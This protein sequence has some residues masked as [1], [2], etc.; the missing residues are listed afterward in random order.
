MLDAAERRDPNAVEHPVARPSCFYEPLTSGLCL[1]I[2]A[3]AF[4][5]T[6]HKSD[7]RSDA[8]IATT[9]IGHGRFPASAIRGRGCSSSAWRLR[10]TVRIGPAGCLRAMAPVA[11]AIS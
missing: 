3:R 4:A 8:R 6:A 1:A 9:R 2:A 5:L 11:P 7:A 10:R